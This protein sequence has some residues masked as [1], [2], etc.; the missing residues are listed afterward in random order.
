V[1]H[2]IEI[3]NSTWIHNHAKVIADYVLPADFRAEI[4]LKGIYIDIQLQAADGSD[5]NIAITPAG[6][7]IDIE[8]KQRYIITRRQMQIE[9]RTE[10]GKLLEYD[11]YHAHN[12]MKCYLAIAIGSWQQIKLYSFKIQIPEEVKSTI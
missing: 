4:E 11:S 9:F 8:E 12:D 7:G 1:D 10:T 6:L 3:F 5:R 2:Y